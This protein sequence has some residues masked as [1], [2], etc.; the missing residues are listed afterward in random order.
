MTNDEIEAAAEASSRVRVEQFPELEWEHSHVVRTEDGL[1]SY[2]IYVAP[3]AQHLRD[4]AA[5]AG[6]PA[7]DVQEIQLDLLP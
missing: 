2:C 7:D 5:A 3:S 1:A 4:H 6:L